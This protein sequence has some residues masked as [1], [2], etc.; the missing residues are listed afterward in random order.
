MILIMAGSIF[1]HHKSG[2]LHHSYNNPKNKLTDV[3]YDKKILAITKEY[4]KRQKKKTQ[5][6]IVSQQYK[7]QTLHTTITVNT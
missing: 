4:Q 6:N 5:F 3:P 1:I 2:L 7:H